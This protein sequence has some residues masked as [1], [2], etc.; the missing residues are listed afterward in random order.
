VHVVELSDL[1][2]NL[3]MK[4]NAIQMYMLGLIY[5]TLQFD[6]SKLMSGIMTTV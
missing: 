5:L 1:I 2:I 4:E 3:H 6:F